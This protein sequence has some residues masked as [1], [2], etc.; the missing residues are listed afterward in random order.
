[1][2]SARAGSFQNPSLLATNRN[3]EIIRPSRKKSISCAFA[4]LTVIVT[5]SVWIDQAPLSF[6]GSSKSSTIIPKETMSAADAAVGE[7]LSEDTGSEYKR[8]IDFKEQ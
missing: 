3:P 6:V 5:V 4:L 7:S 1:M 2:S 8:S